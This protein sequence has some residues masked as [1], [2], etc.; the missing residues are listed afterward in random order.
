[1]KHDSPH[2]NLINSSVMFTF[3]EKHKACVVF[4]L[5]PKTEKELC[6]CC[7]CDAPNP[8]TFWKYVHPVALIEFLYQEVHSSLVHSIT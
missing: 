7:R 6:A 4:F 1:M 8:L 2:F 5:K 3:P